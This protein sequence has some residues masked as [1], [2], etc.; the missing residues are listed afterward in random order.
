MV[1]RTPEEF[2]KSHVDGAFNVP[3]MFITQDGNNSVVYSSV[4][5]V[6]SSNF[7]GMQVNRE[8]KLIL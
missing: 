2:N 4:T 3:Y 5:Y 7:D 6:F 1:C 8:K